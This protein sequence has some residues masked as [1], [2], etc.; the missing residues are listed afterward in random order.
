MKDNYPA[1]HSPAE[2]FVFV[3]T[4]GRSGSTLTQAILNSI[5]GYVI[6]GENGNLLYFFAKAAHL[7]ET[8]RMH[9]IRREDIKKEVEDRSAYLKA[10]LGTALDPWAGV[11]NINPTD[12]RLSLMNLFVEKVLCPPK[13]CRVT[14]FKEIRFHQ[15]P[16][17]FH[18]Y[19]SIVKNTFPGAKFIFQTRNHE[20]VARSG[21]WAKQPKEKVLSTLSSAEHLFEQ[22]ANKN[23]QVCFKIEYENYI[24]NREFLED[25]F[26]FLGEEYDAKRVADVLDQPLRH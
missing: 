9:V 23:K 7:V 2:G 19:L 17:F 25:L 20:D 16:D 21:W 15:D 10:F 22:F 6:R 26:V 24:R 14:G 11:E 3:V 1:L 12:F 5:P 18:P 8:D 13:G 4:Y